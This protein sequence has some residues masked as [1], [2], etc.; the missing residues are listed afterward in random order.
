V[1]NQIS[2]N[3][4]QALLTLH[5]PQL[6]IILECAGYFRYATVE[7]KCFE[8]PEFSKQQRLRQI[9]NLGPTLL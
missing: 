2:L 9:I 5:D 7:N 8:N 4:A 6:K 1:K 3:V